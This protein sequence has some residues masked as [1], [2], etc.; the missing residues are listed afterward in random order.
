MEDV[1][2][3]EAILMQYYNILR[4]YLRDYAISAMLEQG[5]AFKPAK[6][7]GWQ[8]AQLGPEYHVDQPLRTHIING[9]YALTRLLEYLKSNAYYHISETEFKRFL[10][11]FTMHDA[12]KAFELASTRMGRSDFSI[13]LVK[14]DK[15]LEGMR[16]RQFVHV[17][18]EDIRAASV[19]LQSPKVADLSSCTPGISHLLTL[20]HLADQFPSKQTARDYKT[21]KNRLREL[22]KKNAV[23]A[24]QDER[25]SKRTGIPVQTF[26]AKP[27]LALYY[28]ELDE[29]RGLSTLL[30]HQATEQVLDKYGLYPILYFANAIL[31]LGPEGIELQAEDLQSKVAA[32]LFAQVRHEASSESPSIAREACDPRKGLKFEKYAFLFCKL[33][34]LLNAAIESTA[35]N[36]SSGFVSKLLANRIDKKKYA[37]AEDFYKCYE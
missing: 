14:L 26:D 34:D 16:L 23:T 7:Y 35:L 22:T 1:I 37:Q 9:L 17:K 32:N 2:F 29:Y 31:Y 4:D 5:W 18:A 3:Q 21:A 19:S 33:E 30:I 8:Y 20:V 28:H 13:P 24:R 27:P 11:L 15:L 10:I 25:M 36:N 6:L 12:Y